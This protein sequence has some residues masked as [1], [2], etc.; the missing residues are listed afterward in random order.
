MDD[1]GVLSF[2][3]GS[4][5]MSLTSPA[6]L[7]HLEFDIRFQDSYPFDSDIITPF[8]PDRFIENLRDADVWSHLD[9][10]I[11]HPAGSRLKRIDI[12][13]DYTFRCNDFREEHVRDENVVLKA[14]LDGLPSLSTKGILFVKIHFGENHIASF[15][16]SG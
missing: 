11:T 16:Y 10:I 2:L 15:G 3:M 5:G 9:S 1:F 7:E 14:V 13:I 12:N 8:N 6:S 4:L